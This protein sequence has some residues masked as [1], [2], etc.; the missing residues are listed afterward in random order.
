MIVQLFWSFLKLGAFSFGGG[1]AMIPLLEREL[2]AQRHWLTMTEFLD[3]V[4]ISQ[5]TP[6]PIA[7]NA[8]TL[9][10]FRQAGFWG[11]AAA[12]LAVVLPP[13][14]IVW[15][16]ASLVKRQAESTWLKAIFAG[17]RP[18]VAALVAVAAVTVARESLP[19]WKSA[20]LALATL[21]ATGPFRLHPILAILGAGVVGII[22]F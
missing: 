5:M 19:D 12:T 7:I 10:G 6:G 21:V 9:V 2:V 18:L 14:V 1:Y 4:S 22:I 20:A 3:V 8:A 15:T 16:L 11:S 13:V 17:V